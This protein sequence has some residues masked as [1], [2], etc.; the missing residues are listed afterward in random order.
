MEKAQGRAKKMTEPVFLPYEE[1]LKELGWFSFKKRR[2]RWIL[3]RHTKPFF[4]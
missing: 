4:T 2:L 3:S 1:R